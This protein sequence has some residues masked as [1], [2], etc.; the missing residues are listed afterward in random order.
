M[1]SLLLVSATAAAL[2]LALLGGVGKGGEKKTEKEAG[3][4]WV[5][6]LALL[7]LADGGGIVAPRHRSAA[8]VEQ[9]IGLGALRGRRRRLQAGSHD[10][11]RNRAAPGLRKAHRAAG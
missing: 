1:K 11:R 8:L 5:Q 6:L 7:E 2:S 9:K 3:D 4:G 10:Q